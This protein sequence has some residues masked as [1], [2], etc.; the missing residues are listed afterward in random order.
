M[1]AAIDRFSTRLSQLGT[2][3]SLRAQADA[4]PNP[5]ARPRVNAHIHL[6]PN[7]SAFE[8]PTQALD[9]AQAQDVSVLGA[10]NYYDYAVYVEFAEEAGK[11][12]IFP[13]FGLEIIS[14]I[15]ALVQAGVR[16]NDPGNPGKMY[17][18]GK[19]ITRFAPLDNVAAVLLQTIRDQ[20]GARMAAIADRLS[21]VFAHAGVETNLNADAIKQRIAARHG[22]PIGR[23]YL[24]ERHLAQ[25]FQEVAFE[26]IASADRPALFTRVFGVAAKSG[27]DD[28]VGIQNEIRSHLMKAGKAAF[29]PDTFVD[30]EH[31]YRLVLALGGIPCYPT[32]ADGVAPIT[33]YE[34]SVDGLIADLQA[35]GIHS[36]EFV[37]NRNT[38]EVLGQYVRTMRAAGLIVTAGTEHNTLDLLPIE[39]TCVGDAP[40]PDEINEIFYE[41]ACVIAA[42]QFLALQGEPGFVDAHGTPNPAYAT[43]DARIEAFRRLGATVISRYRAG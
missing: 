23:V 25:A 19:G 16:I 7:F 3:E 34:A 28:A 9:L 14:L 43:A 24:Q 29:I 18:C 39:P 41:G 20:D 21:A 5:A 31:A 33:G 40:I 36:A 1:P 30:F 2:P 37:P 22:C 6:P 35:R 27:A 4:N 13:L 15:D 11:R 32:L 8:T 26:K 10:S 12:G 17:L 42:H 38:P